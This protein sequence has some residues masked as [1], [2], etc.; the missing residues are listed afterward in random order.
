MKSIKSRNNKSEMKL[1][2]ALW[3]MGL[4]YRL[5]D[6][7]LPGK[8]DIVFKNRKVAVFVDGSFW[9]GKDWAQKNKSI[10]SNKQ[11]WIPKIERNIQ[12]DKEVNQAL[13]RLGWKIV[14]LWDSE[15]EKALG[16][17]IIQ[18]T[19]ALSGDTKS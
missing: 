6:K 11:F 13:G 8:P 1:R 19:D 2:K 7:S 18:I 17:C 4:R 14:R 15:I 12:R 10:K 9:H 5:Y 3:T 16:K